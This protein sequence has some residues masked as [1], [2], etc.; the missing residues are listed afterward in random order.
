MRPAEGGLQSSYAS[1]QRSDENTK[2]STMHLDA[3]R[4]RASDF[5]SVLSALGRS[6]TFV[7]A[8]LRSLFA[9]VGRFLSYIAALGTKRYPPDTQRRLKIINMI[10]VIIVIT[11]LI[12]AF[13][14]AAADYAKMR[15]VILMNVVLAGIA[16]LV[17]FAHRI[18]DIAGALLIAGAELL[19]LLFFTAYFGRSAG[20]PLMY[21][22]FSAA[23]FVVFGLERIWLVLATVVTALALHLFAWFAYHRSDALLPMDDAF[24]NASYLQGALTTFGLIAASVYYAFSLAERAKAET[25]TVLRNVLPET[26]VERLKAEPE[27]AIADGFTEAS[28]LFAD[29]TGFVAIARG[30]GPE[31]TVEMLNN[32]VSRFDELAAKHGV[33]KIKTIG[34]AYMVASGVPEPRSDH[35]VA[36]ASMAL[37]MLEAVEDTA[38]ELD[39]PINVRAGMASGPMMAGVIGKRKFSYD[40]WGDPVNLASRLEQASKPGRILLCPGCKAALEKD[41]ILEQHGTID[42]KGVGAQDTWYL[43]ARR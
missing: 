7:R 34:D 9:P 32:L 35:A 42:I 37:D 28:V 33:E 31:R 1:Q 39:L 41:F 14:Q 29:I 16:M 24:L 38:R 18:N 12:F 11:T 20:T 26:V 6:L 3:P 19:A 2:T 15:P 25:E 17:P 36:L 22:A 5:T 8:G 40:V 30:L 43:N 27:T 21:V 13:Q 23:P 10:S 4:L